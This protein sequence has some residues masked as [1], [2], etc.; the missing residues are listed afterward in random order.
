MGY[1]AKGEGFICIRKCQL[2]TAVGTLY[3]AVNAA[4]DENTRQ[5][6][7]RFFDN[8]TSSLC[9]LEKLAS[10]CG[11]ECAYDG[12]GAEEECF[13][14]SFDG[15]WHDDQMDVFLSIAQY[16]S[17]GKISM[18]GEDDSLWRYVFGPQYSN[19][20]V[21]QRGEIVYD[22]M[23]Q[24]K[25]DA[26]VQCLKDNGIEADEAETV[27]QALCYILTDKET[28]QYFAN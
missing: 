7:S 16:I 26:A 18:Q 28:A 11:I 27:C 12:S 17:D 19:H 5:T 22:S 25:F 3:D 15:N 1:C 8:K 4:V 23:T 20:Y 6:F 14:I 21:E 9:Q 2:Q 10:A 13:T 24:Q